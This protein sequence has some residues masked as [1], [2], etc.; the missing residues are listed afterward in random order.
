[1]PTQLGNVIL[2]CIILRINFGL[3]STIQITDFYHASEY[4]A[5]ASQAIFK[6]NQESQRT[7]WLEKHCHDLKHNKNSVV[8][9]LEELKKIRDEKKLS[10]SNKEKLNTVI[11][12]FTNQSNRMN[13]SDYREK[14]LPIGSG[15]TE[16]ACK[17]IIKQRLCRSGMR[18]KDRGASIVLAL[19]C[20][21]QS[22]RW[23]QFWHKINQY[24]VP[25]I[26]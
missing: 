19:K 7:T 16:A 4:L 12:Y 8:E 9:Q 21:V 24:G 11:T 14:H 13:Y 25:S 5:C 20:L 3:S 18:W 15:V 10:A 6:Y 22:K 1:M 23:G 26:A 2:L 17:T